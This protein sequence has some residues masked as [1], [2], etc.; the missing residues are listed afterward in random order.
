MDSVD[1]DNLLD[2]VIANEPATIY[3]DLII[4]GS[5]F[6]KIMD[7]NGLITFLMFTDQLFSLIVFHF[8]GTID[9][10][11]SNAPVTWLRYLANQTISGSLNVNGSLTVSQFEQDSWTI[12]SIDLAELLSR[13]VR[14]DQLANFTSFQFGNFVNIFNIDMF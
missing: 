13:A 11:D 5:V 8:L 10:V 6:T 14:I 9:E 3:S 4:N 7:V 1:I 12:N 2:A